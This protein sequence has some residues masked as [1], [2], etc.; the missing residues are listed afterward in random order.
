MSESCRGERRPFKGSQAYGKQCVNLWDKRQKPALSLS[1]LC[2]LIYE[3]P[4]FV[5]SYSTSMDH[6]TL[7]WQAKLLLCHAELWLRQSSIFSVTKAAL[8]PSDLVEIRFRLCSG[9]WVEKTFAW[10][11]APNP[12]SPDKEVISEIDPS[13]YFFLL[14]D[15]S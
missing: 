14:C 12:I 11:N 2:S 10:M 7:S 15:I 6:I 9:A 3:W 8:W 1:L 4:S 5:S 13:S